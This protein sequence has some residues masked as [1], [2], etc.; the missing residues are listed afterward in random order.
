MRANSGPSFTI[1]RNS[2]KL[3]RILWKFLDRSTEWDPSYWPIASD[4]DLVQKISRKLA[5]NRAL[6]AIAQKCAFAK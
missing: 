5:R 6:S 4:P 1:A 3:F 2:L